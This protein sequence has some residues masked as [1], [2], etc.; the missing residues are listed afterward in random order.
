MDWTS[1]HPIE[2]MHSYMDYL[3]Y[4]FDFVSTE[5]IGKSHEGSNMRILKVCRGGCGGKPAMWIDGGIHARE[6]ISPA[7]A[8]YMMM[9]LVENDGAHSDLT[10]ELD[11]YCL[12]YQGINL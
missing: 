9:E 8:T 7:V 11:W 3:E 5:S 6:W 4:T 10:A 1:Y 12:I 2:D